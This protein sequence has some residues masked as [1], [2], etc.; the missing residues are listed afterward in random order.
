MSTKRGRVLCFH[1]PANLQLL[2]GA[3]RSF[4]LQ[5]IT[6]LLMLKSITALFAPRRFLRL[7]LAF[8][9]VP[10]MV[11]GVLYDLPTVVL[12]SAN[13]TTVFVGAAGTRTRICP[14][15]R[16]HDCA[17]CEGWMRAG[18]CALGAPPPHDPVGF[19][20]PG[21][22]QPTHEGGRGN[23][24]PSS[25]NVPFYPEASFAVH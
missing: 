11:L 19:Q 14:L 24:P 18:P 4:L 13:Q 21:A 2:T 3:S 25:I 12:G 8:W 6:D 22:S 23:S 15:A 9:K 7:F 1:P 5:V 17:G 20:P 16:R 10:R